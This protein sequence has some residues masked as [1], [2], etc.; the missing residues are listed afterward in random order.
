MWVI[1]VL[2]LVSLASFVYLYKANQPTVYFSMPTRFWELA[3][4]CLLF[5]SMREF[6][7]IFRPLEA[8]PASL[9]V[10]TLLGVLFGPHQLAVAAT[11][12]VV[13]LTAA[14]IARLGLPNGTLRIFTH[15]WVVYIGLISYSLYLWH[16][17]VLSLSRWTI[18]IHWWTVPFQVAAM[19]LLAIG[20]YRYIEK[21][22]RR[23]EW[24]PIRWR[25]IVYGMIAT[26]CAAGVMVGVFFV[27]GWLY[28]GQKYMGP[29]LHEE[30]LIKGTSVNQ[31]N[32]MLT[33]GDKFSVSRF[34]ACHLAAR[35][36]MPTIF[37]VGS[38]HAMHLAG[39]GEGLHERGFGVALLATQGHNF[40]PEAEPDSDTFRFR[41]AQDSAIFSILDS[42]A[43]RGSVVVIA[44]RYFQDEY[45]RYFGD[46]YF[47]GLNALAR[48]FGRKGVT[49]VQVLP[50]PEY[51]FHDINQC[52]PQWF[53]AGMRNSGICLPKDALTRIRQ[54]K[55]VAT[56]SSR[57]ENLVHYDP[58][59]VLCPSGMAECY[60][61]HPLSKL[62]MFRNSDHLS[63]YGA[64]LLIDDFIEFMV[65][66][67][68]I[69]TND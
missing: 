34:D 8:V 28:T 40:D 2:S 6:G 38:S 21:P 29:S 4:G 19:L 24:S 15:Q 68:L 48:W 31:K 66:H 41:S 20:S 13:T 49:V 23:S 46:S 57:S 43:K 17:A 53:N 69:P 42:R 3:A 51:S 7:S 64:S 9:L 10:V 60:P 30:N 12:A 58:V 67:G 55:D 54:S 37:F 22:L 26:V 61:I 50:L 35:D 36:G 56:R 59:K 25:S 52:S 18:G 14:L 33:G 27:R 63:N 32:C 1:G 11:V 44:N 47:G 45:E 5:V 65:L 16:W 62:P 39:L